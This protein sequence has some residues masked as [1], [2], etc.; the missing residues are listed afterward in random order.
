MQRLVRQVPIASHLT[1]YAVRLLEATHPQ[2]S[3]APDM[4]R[5][6]VRY[7]GSPRG[8]QAMIIAAKALA[9]IDNRHNVDVYDLQT[10]ILPALRHRLILNFEGQAEGITPDEILQNVLQNARY[11]S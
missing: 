3:T 9:L 5:R 4:V 11:G 1:S 6:Y 7:G 2:H 8:L 10:A